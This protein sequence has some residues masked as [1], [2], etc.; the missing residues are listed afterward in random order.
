MIFEPLYLATTTCRVI[1]AWLKHD[2]II[3]EL[4]LK[5]PPKRRFSAIPAVE[6]PTYRLTLAWST[7]IG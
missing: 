7:E 2:P 3:L 6:A 5:N 4:E 1:T